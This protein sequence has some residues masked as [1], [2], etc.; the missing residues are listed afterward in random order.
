MLTGANKNLGA[1]DAK[2]TIV[3]RRRFSLHLTEIGTTVRLCQTHGAAPDATDQVG[4]IVFF[5][6]LCTTRFQ[7]G[8]SPSVRPGYIAQAQLAVVIISLMATPIDAGK[9]L[10]TQCLFARQ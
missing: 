2:A 6:L 4:Q 10:T 5:L 3:I 7:G 9:A 1:I 8:D